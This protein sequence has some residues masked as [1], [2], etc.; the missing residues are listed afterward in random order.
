MTKDALLVNIR[1]L[2]GEINDT[3]EAFLT[4]Q[5][6]GMTWEIFFYHRWRHLSTRQRLLHHLVTLARSMAEVVENV[7]L[8]QPDRWDQNDAFHAMRDDLEEPMGNALNAISAYLFVLTRTDS[9]SGR[10][11]H[12]MVE[13]LSPE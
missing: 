4:S 7:H 9:D 12:Q 3:E 1:E 10:H 2:S 5:E 8:S 13:Y 11:H 6:R